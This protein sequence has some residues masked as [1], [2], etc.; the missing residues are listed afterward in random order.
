MQRLQDGG[1]SAEKSSELINLIA[2]DTGPE[3]KA[4]RRMSVK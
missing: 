4:C 3:A 2:A 1:V